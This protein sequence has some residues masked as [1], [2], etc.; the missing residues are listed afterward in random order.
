M[1][2]RTSASAAAKAKRS[3][4]G[5]ADDFSACFTSDNQ[6]LAVAA[7]QKNGFTSLSLEPAVYTLTLD[8]GDAGREP[9][10]LEPEQGQTLEDLNVQDPVLAG[11]TFAGWYLDGETPS[12]RSSR[13]I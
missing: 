3:L 6:T 13:S 8:L 10:T 12:T 5:Y 4:T 1:R 7:A 2:S 9:V 11:S